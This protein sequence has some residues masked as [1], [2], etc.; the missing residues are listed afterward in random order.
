MNTTVGTRG[1]TTSAG[2]RGAAGRLVPPGTAVQRQPARPAAARPAAA[3]PAAARPAAARPAAARP[4]APRP[5]ASRSPV[6]RTPFVLL[7]L[8]LLG[9]ALIC[10]L[11]IN[12]TLATASFRITDLQRD[13][14]ALSRQ[15]QALQEQVAAAESP[16]SIE[17]R[18]YRL[19][20]RPQSTLNFLDLRTGRSYTQPTSASAAAAVPGYTP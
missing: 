17:Q 18:A 16:G 11:V 2:R 12:T 8:G 19:G 10:L 20:M 4:A 14:A 1:P 6:S 15:Q 13:N 3:R 7:V 5:A 9:G